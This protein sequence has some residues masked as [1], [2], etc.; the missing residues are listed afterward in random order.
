NDEHRF[1]YRVSEDAIPIAQL[2]YHY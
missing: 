1:V 2:R